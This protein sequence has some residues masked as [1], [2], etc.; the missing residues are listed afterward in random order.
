MLQSQKI[1][2]GVATRPLQDVPG[3][4]EYPLLRDPFVLACPRVESPAPETLLS[5]KTRLPFLRY[6]RNQIIGAQIE[7]QLRRL[8][9]ALPNQFELESNQSIMGIVAEGSGWAISTPTCYLRAKRFHDRV[10]LHPFPGKEFSRILSMFTTQSFVHPVSELV[11][12][13]LRRLIKRQVVD[14]LTARTPWLAGSYQV[15]PDHAINPRES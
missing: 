2:A 4:V 10:V 6:S 5:G 12:V 3:L 8:R 13:T 7:T 1:D 11:L 9:I 14:P 15:E